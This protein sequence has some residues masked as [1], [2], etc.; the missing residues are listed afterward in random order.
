VMDS[1]VTGGIVPATTRITRDPL[2]LLI[3]KYYSALIRPPLLKTG[4]LPDGSGGNF[5]IPFTAF[6]KEAMKNRDPGALRPGRH[7]GLHR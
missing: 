3:S 2:S 6:M 1:I 7:H 5:P 4:S